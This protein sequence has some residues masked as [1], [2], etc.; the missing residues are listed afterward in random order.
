MSL[1]MNPDRVI[2][3]EVRGDEVIPM[4]NAMSQGNDGSMCTLHADSSATVFNK[5]ALYGM[6]ARAAVAGGHQ[7]AG[8]RRG[9]PRR[10]H[11]QARQPTGR[12]AGPSGGGAD[13]RQVITNEL[14]GP[15]PDGAARPVTPCPTT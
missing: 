12:R 3:G 5:L 9:R 11:R 14:Y 4:L 15:G 7:P 10:V 13:G 2:V 8:R 6:Q 1:R